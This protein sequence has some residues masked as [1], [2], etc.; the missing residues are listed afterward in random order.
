MKKK[1]TVRPRAH[2]VRIKNALEDNR[3]RYRTIRGV[4]KS[5]GVSAEQVSKEIANRPGEIVVLARKNQ[6]GENLYTTR[7]H[8]KKK[9]KF[10]EK[11]MGALLNRVY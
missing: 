3:F 4:A 7:K 1:V 5:A 10:S 2:S 9:A 11:L 6:S 8:Y